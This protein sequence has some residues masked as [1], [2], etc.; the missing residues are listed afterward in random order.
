MASLARWVRLASMRAMQNI[1]EAKRLAGA[2]NGLA[3]VV[4]QV[5]TERVRQM[6][7]ATDRKLA[8]LPARA[9]DPVLTKRELA[10][11]FRV[12]SRTIDNWMHR[13]YLPYLKMGRVVRFRWS[14][15]DRQLSNLEIGRLHWRR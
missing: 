13:G 6:E 5:I 11:R 10:A 12:N 9:G 3:V 2:I 4:A 15:V 1:S 8:D 7:E 14:E